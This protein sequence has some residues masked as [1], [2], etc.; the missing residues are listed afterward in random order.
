MFFCCHIISCTRI[1]HRTVIV[2]GRRARLDIGKYIER[3]PI[4][5]VIDIIGC[6][7]QLDRIGIRRSGAVLS[8]AIGTAKSA[9]FPE[10]TVVAALTVISKAVIA[11]ALLLFLHD[12]VIRL[13]HFLKPLLRLCPIRIV[14]IRVRMI[15]AAEVSICFFDLIITGT[16]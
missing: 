1:R 3:L 12:L 16:G 13:L 14:D 10:T 11:V 15:P 9:K 6:C 4:T 7:L 2:P 5:A 8:A